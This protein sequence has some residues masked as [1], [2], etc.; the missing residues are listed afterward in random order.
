M[1]MHPEIMM[2]LVNDRHRELVA[3]ADRGRLLRSARRLLRAGREP[4]RGGPGT[5]KTAGTLSPC[6]SSAVAPAR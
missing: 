3:E 6:E 2:S 1:L 5:A 4:V